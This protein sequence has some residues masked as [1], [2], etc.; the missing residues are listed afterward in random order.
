MKYLIPLVL[1]AALTLGGGC[2]VINAVGDIEKFVTELVVG[3]P[4]KKDDQHFQPHKKKQYPEWD[5]EANCNLCKQPLFRKPIKDKVRSLRGL[6]VTAGLVLFGGG[7]I[8]GLVLGVKWK[9]AG[10]ITGTGAILAVLAI[11]LD[12]YLNII[13]IAVLICGGLVGLYLLYCNRKKIKA[14]INFG[15]AVIKA[16]ELDAAAIDAAADTAIGPADSPLRNDIK[17]TVEKV[18]NGGGK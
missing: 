11:L 5:G 17:A 7:I 18:R 9:V 10:P 16:G 3:K 14:M 4:K 13:I 15:D 8:A 1:L 6:G 2:A 12:A